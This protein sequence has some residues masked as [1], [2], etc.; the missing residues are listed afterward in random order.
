MKGLS[1]EEPQLSI[2]KEPT[3]SLT[4]GN[5][6]ENQ[7]FDLRLTKMGSFEAERVQQ[8]LKERSQ[9]VKETLKRL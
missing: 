1:E 6:F 4:F 5:Y 2:N 7:N 3:S 9:Q 8:D